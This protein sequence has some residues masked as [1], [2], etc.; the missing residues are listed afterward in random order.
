VGRYE[1]GLKT[2]L[3]L[4]K[5]CP[6][7]PVVWYNLACSYALTSRHDEAFSSLSRAVDLGYRDVGWIRKDAD[8]ASIR[9]DQRFEALLRRLVQ[10]Q[11]AKRSPAADH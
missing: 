2:D 1:D 4:S 5:L 11:P 3:E 8:L 7:E 10:A 6:A 9:K